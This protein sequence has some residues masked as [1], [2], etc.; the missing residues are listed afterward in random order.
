[1]SSANSGLQTEK[2]TEQSAL[3]KYRNKKKTKN[4]KKVV[5]KVIDLTDNAVYAVLED[6]TIPF[7]ERMEKIVEMLTVDLDSKEAVAVSAEHMVQVKQIVKELLNRFTAHNRKSIEFTRD[8]PLNQLKE[9]MQEVF[10]NYHKISEGRSD[11]KGKL[12]TVDD[13][14]KKVGGEDKLVVALLEA[15]TREA[16]REAAGVT[17]AAAIAASR[18][19]NPCS[20]AR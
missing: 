14:I 11:L 3:E 12:G 20:W 10:D 9:S 7:E 19:R 5:A 4:E 16:E 2:K 18:P 8:N 13:L 1:M 6:S 17:V 15:K